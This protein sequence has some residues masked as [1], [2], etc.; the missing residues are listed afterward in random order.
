[1]APPARDR[2]GPP[3]AGRACRSPGG[4]ALGSSEGESVR[5]V[6]ERHYGGLQI[7]A[8]VPMKVGVIWVTVRPQSATKRSLFE[9]F[10][11]RLSPRRMSRLSWRRP[12]P[13]DE[14]REESPGRVTRGV[15]P[16][17]GCS[18]LSST[19]AG[20]A[21]LQ[22]S[23]NGSDSHLAES[24]GSERSCHQGSAQMCG[25]EGGAVVEGEVGRSRAMRLLR[26]AGLLSVRG[27]RR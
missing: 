24:S 12:C 27:T 7:P 18:P 13:G 16:A 15:P 4:S 5:N 23:A 3:P 20:P 9:V 21:G 8:W 6:G 14:H 10:R 11:S 2:A 1:M 26:S 17:N 25:S 19:S 22:C